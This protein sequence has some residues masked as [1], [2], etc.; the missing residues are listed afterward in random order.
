LSVKDAAYI[1][2]LIDGEGTITL[3]R[4]HR[5][6]NR[7]LAITIASTE[8]QLLEF[9]LD[10]SGVGTITSKK[11][12]QPHHAKSFTYAVYSRQALALLQQ[13]DSYLLS[14]KKKRAALILK[15]YVSLTPRNGKYSAS[16]KEQRAE[17]EEKFLR[18]KPHQINEPRHTYHANN[19]A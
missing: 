1:A 19:L 5:N 6:E 15:E 11:T 2:G 14:Y 18:I 10:A 3:Q 17:F 7:R 16:L 4:K 9:V 13:I 8:R 12:Y